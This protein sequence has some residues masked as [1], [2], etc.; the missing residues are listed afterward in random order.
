MNFSSEAKGYTSKAKGQTLRGKGET[1][2]QKG[3]IF[4]RA[5]SKGKLRISEA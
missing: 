1:E 4:L 2:K 5:A 3:I